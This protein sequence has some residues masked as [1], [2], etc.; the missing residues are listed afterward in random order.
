MDEKNAQKELE[1]ASAS[2][3]KYEDK[4]LSGNL[5]ED[6]KEFVKGRIKFHSDSVI[7]V[8]EFLLDGALRSLPANTSALLQDGESATV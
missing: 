3:K 7:Q 8:R 2:L 1:K 5:T 6:E 4:Y